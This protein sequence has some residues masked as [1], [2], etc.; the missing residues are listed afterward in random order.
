[1]NSFSQPV[2]PFSL[3]SEV[4]FSRSN[5]NDGFEL[6]PRWELVFERRSTRDPRG[7]TRMETKI[8]RR[9]RSPAVWA[10]V[11]LLGLP[12]LAEAQVSGLFP[13]GVIRRQR[14]PCEMEDPVYKHYRHEFFGYHPTCWR[15]FP[16][17]WGCPS[18]Y[19][20]AQIREESY[21][22]YPRRP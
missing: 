10:V 20:P 21:R 5:D 18:P 12:A 11:G 17:G 6:G 2:S 7:E 15:Q 3:E 8:R 13:N 14:V 19:G 22:L 4:G 16:A 1:V 9:W